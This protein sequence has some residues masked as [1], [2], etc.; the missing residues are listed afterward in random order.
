[1]N[2]IIKNSTTIFGIIIFL[3][4]I[5]CIV[6]FTHYK[7]E[8]VLYDLHTD[9]MISDNVILNNFLDSGET[10]YYIDS[11][12]ESKENFVSTVPVDLKFGMYKLVFHYQSGEGGGHSYTL[13]GDNMDFREMLGNNHKRLPSDKKIYT[14]NV[15]LS[16]KMPNFEVQFSF[17][18]SGYLFISQVEVIENRNWVIGAGVSLLFIFLC[19]DIL[20]VFR[21]QVKKKVGEKEWKNRVLAL[22]I[23]IFIASLPLFNPYLFTGVDWGFHLQRIEGIKEG[24]QSGQFPVRMQPQWMNGYGYG[25]SLFYGDILLYFPALLRML[26]MGVQAAY[27]CFVLFTNILTAGIAYCSFKRLFHDERIGL[28]GCMLYTTSVYRMNLIY[29]RTMVG[30]YC[31]FIFLPLIIV[32]VYEILWQENREKN[33]CSSWLMGTIGFSGLILSHIISTELTAALVIVFCLVYWKRTFRKNALLQFLKMGI[34]ILVCTMWFIVPF[35]DM[36]REEYWFSK[37]PGGG[38][39]TS[40]T[41]LGQLF[42][43]FPY[44]AGTPINYTVLEGVGVG[45]ELIYSV[46]GG[47]S[48][49][50]VLFIIYWINYGQKKSKYVV[51][52]KILLVVSGVL[53]FMTT[54]YFPWNDLARIIGTFSFMIGNIQFPYRLLGLVTLSLTALALLTT[55]AFAEA[56]AGKGNFVCVTILFF[57]II[58]SG[59][60][61]GRLI[62]ENHTTYLHNSDDLDTY[63]TALGEYTPANAD[64]GVTGNTQPIYSEGILIES[65]ERRY[66]KFD[67]TCS[68][69]ADSEEYIDLPLLYYKGYGARAS[70]MEDEIRVEGNEFGC[71]RVILPGGFSG[72]ITVNYYGQWYW[73]V[74]DIISLAGILIFGVWR[75]LVAAP[76][77]YRRYVR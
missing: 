71:L 41:F 43:I 72:D 57:A 75:L 73:R 69:Q 8:R 25:V 16:R 60:F 37:N 35:L 20:F 36:F 13:A 15:W 19:M 63:D 51:L 66:Q 50:I 55:K 22:S 46:G 3:Q 29:K 48:A 58:S 18:G 14:A 17:G 61:E 24:I 4:L 52:G 10:G 44:S 77:R 74:A 64:L 31:A 23:I 33:R 9:H 42:N 27:K 59:Y 65:I 49:G 30:E 28:L 32:A 40:G 5:I 54:I 1:M 6:V 39:Q 34:G 12:E 47:L 76:G 67:I 26:G 53:M 2:K 68:N 7:S 38:I 11:S 21:S 56:D 45:D 62:N 70:A